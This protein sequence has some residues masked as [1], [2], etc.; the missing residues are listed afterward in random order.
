MAFSPSESPAVTIRE[1]DLSGIVPAV[2]SSTGAIVGDFNW[3]PTNQPILIGNEAEL[4]SN[5]GSPTLV[6]DSSNVDF[7]S[8]SSFLKYSGSLYVTR[9]LDAAAKNAVDSASSVGNSPVVEGLSSWNSQKSGFMA[10]GSNRLVAKYPGE[11]GNSLA[12]S[13]CPWSGVIADGG[14]SVDAE[15][16]DSAFNAW[17]YKSFFDD[18][19]GTSSHVSARSADSATAHDEIHVVV[20]DEGGKFSGTPGTVLETWPFLSLAT[21]AKTPDGSSNFALDVLNSKSAFIWA[22]AIDSSGKPTNVLSASFANDTVTDQDVRTQS[23]NG[24]NQASG[25]LSK[26]EYLVGFD[27]YEDVDTIQVDFLIAPSLGSEADQKAI[28]VDLESTARGLRKDCVVVASPAREHVINVQNPQTIVTNTTT[29]AKTLPSSS[30]LIMDNNFLK[31]YDKYSDEYVFIPAASST[32]GLMAATDG[33]AA[34]WYSPAGN[35]RGQYFGVSSLAYNATKSQRDSLYKAG[36]N[37]VVNL[38]GQGVLLFGDKTK[39][40]R[41]SAF[42]RINVRRLFLV[43]ER[44]IKSAAQ[45]VMFEFNDEF[46]RA[47][48]VNI[49]EPFLREIKG[50]RGITDF[51]VVCDETNNTGQVIDNN[52][53]VA[54][55]YVKPARSIN[56]VT[57]SFVAVRTGVDFDEVVGLA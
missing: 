57:L 54:D 15:G 35:R 20:L 3:G 5:F 10:S 25:G 40:G 27:Q 18:A 17:A 29:F 16:Q 50:R 47:E 52:Q 51:R 31:V 22:S 14:T 23:F 46:T 38:P 6:I 34:P 36:I 55:I 8:A 4:V 32:A 53:F 7:L 21:D 1:V 56:Y 9:G 49:V 48:F 26:D 39:L 11:V 2:T 13:I 43:M 45:N 41:P 24:G 42:D 12:I 19:P 44:A 37:P 33:N 30:Y 28:I